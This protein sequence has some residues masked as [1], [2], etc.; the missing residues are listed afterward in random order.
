MRLKGAIEALIF[1]SELPLKLEKITELLA[2][3]FA[4]EF[5]GHLD[6]KEVK[7]LIENIREEY[8]DEGRGI[9]LLEIAGGYQFRTKTCHASLLQKLRAKRPPKFGRA[10]MEALAIIAYRQPVTRAE[11]EDLRGVDSGGVVRSLLEKRLVKILGKKEVPGRPMIYG[12]SRFFLEHFGLRDLSQLPSLKEFVEL[13]ENEEGMI[14]P[15]N[16]ELPYDAI[17]G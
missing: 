10:A 2:G 3:D 16:E 11:I 13:D 14:S 6:K 7:T 15:L 12:T 5:D 4:G 17:E 9:S 8:E 1:A